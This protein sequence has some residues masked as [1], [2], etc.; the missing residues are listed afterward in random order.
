MSV[1]CFFMRIISEKYLNIKSFMGQRSIIF[2][3]IFTSVA[4]KIPE[5]LIYQK[6]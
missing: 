3:V 1:V 2:Q 6:P 4:F 5:N